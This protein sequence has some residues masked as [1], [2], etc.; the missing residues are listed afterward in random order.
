MQFWLQAS[1]GRFVV[2]SH[3][4]IED[5]DEAWIDGLVDEINGDELVI[6]CTSGKK[7]NK[8]PCALFVDT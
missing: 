1:K 5:P 4:W 7:V 8:L 2:G 6:N 3:V